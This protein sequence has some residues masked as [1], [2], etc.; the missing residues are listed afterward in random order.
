VSIGGTAAPVGFSGLTPNLAG[1]YQ[2]NATIGAG[3]PT[4]PQSLTI[5]IGGATSAA[6]NTFIH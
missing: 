2:I 3:T 1:L 6:V 4:G 5:S